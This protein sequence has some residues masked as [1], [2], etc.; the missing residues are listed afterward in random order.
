MEVIIK[1]KMKKIAFAH[2]QCL[3]ALHSRYSKWKLQSK[4]NCIIAIE[5][6]YNPPSPRRT[7]S[8][9]YGNKD[10]LVFAWEHT[11]ASQACSVSCRKKWRI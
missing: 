10:W 8:Y 5:Y 11:V 3:L 7:I 6:L 2:I 9:T 4:K 1:E